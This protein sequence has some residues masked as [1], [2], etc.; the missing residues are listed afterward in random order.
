M[1]HNIFNSYVFDYRWLD[2]T[3]GKPYFV[4]KR[5]KVKRSHKRGKK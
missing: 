1:F 2:I 4:P 5:K 3:T